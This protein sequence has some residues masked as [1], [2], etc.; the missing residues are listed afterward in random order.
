MG[1]DLGAGACH[2][3]FMCAESSGFEEGKALC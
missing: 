1:D 2:G 3:P